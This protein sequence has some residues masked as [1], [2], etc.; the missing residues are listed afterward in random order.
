MI[1]G[2]RFLIIGI[3]FVAAS[4]SGDDNGDDA[5]AEPEI[6]FEEQLDI[7]IALIDEYLAT[8][9]I[10]AEIHES[11]LRY[12]INEQ[13]EGEMPDARSTVIVAYVGM[14]FDG[15]VFDQS[16]NFEFNLSTLIEGWRIG[17]PLIN[18]G[19]SIT[20]YIP[21]GYAYGSSG[22]PGNVDPNTNLIFD[23]S[24]LGVR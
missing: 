12:V 23:V 11:G 21:S 2:F 22:I 14:F 8:N 16:N 20:L 17:I 13:G 3:V 10:E 15:E 7:D 1:R 4:C 19:G 18:S 9:N 24:L 5:P 6:S